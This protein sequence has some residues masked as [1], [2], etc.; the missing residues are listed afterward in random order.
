MSSNTTQTGTVR[1]DNSA[2]APKKEDIKAW[3]TK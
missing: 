2:L 1:K 3:I